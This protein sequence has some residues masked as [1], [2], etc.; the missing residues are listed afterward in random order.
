[1]LI[2]GM[3]GWLP[4]LVNAVGLN[5]RD[6]IRG[7]TVSGQ[8]LRHRNGFGQA[9]KEFTFEFPWRYVRQVSTPAVSVVRNHAIAHESSG[10]H[11]TVI[12]TADRV[13][14]PRIQPPKR[15]LFRHA[16]GGLQFSRLAE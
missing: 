15:N 4:H 7:A 9:P 12:R 3:G 13:A 8:K 14:F 11:G 2:N 5:L 1:M 6:G 16:H 10:T